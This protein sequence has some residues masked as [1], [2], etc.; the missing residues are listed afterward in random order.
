M[1]FIT[2]SSVTLEGLQYESVNITS[3]GMRWVC[4]MKGIAGAMSNAF[5]REGTLMFQ[6]LSIRQGL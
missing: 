1:A 4:S 2:L 5:L 6:A 3:L